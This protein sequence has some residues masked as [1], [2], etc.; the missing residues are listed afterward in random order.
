M[1]SFDWD[2]L[3]VGLPGG[4]QLALVGSTTKRMRI[5]VVAIDENVGRSPERERNA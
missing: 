4:A 3:T 2:V 5:G 1:T